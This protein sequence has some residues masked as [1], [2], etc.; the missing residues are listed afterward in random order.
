MEMLFRNGSWL[1]INDQFEKQARI[2]HYE[3]VISP[4]KRLKRLNKL[5]KRS[6]NYMESTRISKMI[7]ET[8]NEIH[9][10][11]KVYST[12]ISKSVL[13]MCCDCNDLITDE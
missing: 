13:K 11:S 1:I 3:R 12:P 5:L 9:G 8:R 10:K 6:K 7:H 4:E 2:D